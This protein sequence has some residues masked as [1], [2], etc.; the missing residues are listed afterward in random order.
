MDYHA[1]I[2]EHCSYE[3]SA[4]E[5]GVLKREYNRNGRLG[6]IIATILFPLIIYYAYKYF[7]EI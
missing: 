7:A 6:A 5:L 1:S 2:C 3:H 4:E